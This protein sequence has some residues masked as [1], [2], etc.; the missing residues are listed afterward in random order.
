V[1]PS[2]NREPC[3]TDREAALIVSDAIDGVIHNA[4]RRGALANPAVHSELV[5]LIS[6]YLADDDTGGASAG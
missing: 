1:W 2:G 5:R 6:R 3:P 4:A